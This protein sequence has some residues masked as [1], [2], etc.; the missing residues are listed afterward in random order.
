MNAKNTFPT[1]TI[2]VCAVIGAVA[3][4]C[5]A[6]VSL[7]GDGS[8]SYE[9]IVRLNA[10]FKQASALGLSSRAKRAERLGT[11][12]LKTTDE[13]MLADLLVNESF[14]D[15]F[16]RA[17]LGK[18]KNA[19]EIERIAT[20]FKPEPGGISGPGGDGSADSVYKAV[21][22]RLPTDDAV[23]RVVAARMA[24]PGAGAMQ[25]LC[26]RVLDMEDAAR[27]K[28][29]ISKMS[30]SGG[31]GKLP[32][33]IR[34]EIAVRISDPHIREAAGVGKEVCELADLVAKWEPETM[35]E[36][37]REILARGRRIRDDL[38]WVAVVE[39]FDRDFVSASLGEWTEYGKSLKPV[40]DEIERLSSANVELSSDSLRRK[41]AEEKRSKAKNDIEGVAKI[42][43]AVEEMDSMTAALGGGKL[44]CDKL[45]V[46]FDGDDPYETGRRIAI[47]LNELEREAK[48]DLESAERELSAINRKREDANADTA[49]KIVE[50]KGRLSQIRDRFET[51]EAKEKRLRRE[52]E[53]RRILEERLARERKER[54]EREAKERQAREE[55][56]AREQKAREAAEAE[57][58]A[59]EEAKRRKVLA[60]AETVLA[61]KNKDEII[62]HLVE[63]MVGIHGEEGWNKYS[64]KVGKYEVT[65]SEWAAVT[66]E[67]PSAF[68]GGDNPVENVS[69]SDCATFMKKLNETPIVIQSGLKF[70]FGTYHE[71][72]VGVRAGCHVESGRWIQESFRKNEMF[73]KKED[74][75]PIEEF[76]WVKE[77]SMEKTHPVGTKRPNRHGIHDALGNVEE[78]IAPSDGYKPP[79]RTRGYSWAEE[80]PREGFGTSIY[81]PDREYKAGENTKSPKIG[82][83]LF[84]DD[85]GKPRKEPSHGPK[86]LPALEKDME[87]IHVDESKWKWESVD[88]GVRIV[89]AEKLRRGRNSPAFALWIPD[90]LGGV[91]VVALSHDLFNNEGK[92]LNLSAVR[93]PSTVRDIGAESFF[94][95]DKLV[96]VF[97]FAEKAPIRTGGANF[98][99][100][101]GSRSVRLHVPKAAS[102]YNGNWNK[103]KEVLF[104]L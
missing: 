17:I 83:R 34:E 25:D 12:I 84:A 75:G 35:K 31:F 29:L 41:R 95:Q 3:A 74:L 44:V 30:E 80:I 26:M 15:R 104:D 71:W 67:N 102:G 88:G 18:I 78:W 91:P 33:E 63:N 37:V 97:L 87:W 86:T 81:Q 61:G 56:L 47:K 45:G 4:V 2:A 101:F 50:L 66:G 20:A 32:R 19:G 72:D 62:L 22:D 52:A 90:T 89:S 1:R 98:D 55:R 7:S 21:L 85:D 9:Q 6:I 73:S 46:W 70:R 96:D 79:D 53:E 99:A 82:L 24:N 36:P 23:E 10:E 93:I 103:A 42:R 11:A 69:Y 94:W 92:D 49:R 27:S 43:K 68:L 54:E 16:G 76:A 8:P 40:L 14:E 65:Q 64:F 13:T 38:V 60:Q 77:N 58:R 5:F 100:F 51:E 57:R 48:R 39:A 59:R 28:A